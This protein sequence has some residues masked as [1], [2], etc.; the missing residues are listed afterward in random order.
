[1]KEPIDLRALI[2]VSSFSSDQQLLISTAQGSIKRQM[3]QTYEAVKR[4]E[5][6]TA[7]ELGEGDQL[8]AGEGRGVGCKMEVVKEVL[9]V[10]M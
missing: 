1:L 7:I 6:S 10:H 3:L 8:V 9:C 4:R 5:G 2:P